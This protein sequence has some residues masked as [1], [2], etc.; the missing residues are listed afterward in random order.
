MGPQPHY[1]LTPKPASICFFDTN[2]LV[3]AVDAGE[4]GEPRGGRST[5]LPARWRDDQR[6]IL[7]T[8]VLQELFYSITTCA[9]CA[10]PCR[11]RVGG[12]P[13]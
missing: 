3:Y 9:S 10:R 13:W 11:P 6:G 5:A 8:Q 7:S 12:A 1:A 4:P 2:V